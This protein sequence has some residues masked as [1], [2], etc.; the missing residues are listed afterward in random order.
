MYEPRR[1]SSLTKYFYNSNLQS[2]KKLK[3]SFPESSR[4]RSLPLIFF[5]FGMQQLIPKDPINLEN[6]KE[7]EN[8]SL[9]TAHIYPDR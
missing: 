7:R 2:N 5:L 3:K 1:P 9:H 6:E 8:T 4:S